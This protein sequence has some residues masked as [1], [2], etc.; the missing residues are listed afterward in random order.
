MNGEVH[1]QS[2]ATD[3]SGTVERLAEQH[4]YGD[5]DHT[6]VLTLHEVIEAGGE[7][8]IDIGVAG[9]CQTR[10]YLA[11]VVGRIGVCPSVVQTEPETDRLVEETG[12][13]ER[14]IEAHTDLGRTVS[15]FVERRVQTSAEGYTDIVI[16]RHCLRADRDGQRRSSDSNN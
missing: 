8:I 15:R 7:G 16:V 13:E 4:L 10:R 6:Y 5:A 12:V 9:M 1:R 14:S 11:P 2:H 3:E